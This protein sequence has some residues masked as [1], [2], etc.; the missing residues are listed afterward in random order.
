MGVNVRPQE[1][2]FDNLL[3]VVVI[4]VGRRIVL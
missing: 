4:V 3:R 2:G 1:H